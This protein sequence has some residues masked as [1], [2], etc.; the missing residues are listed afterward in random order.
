M[1]SFK[2]LSAEIS[3]E[4]SISGLKNSEISSFPNGTNDKAPTSSYSCQLQLVLRFHPI[5][6]FLTACFSIITSRPAPLTLR[7]AVTDTVASSN[8]NH[9]TEEDRTVQSTALF[10]R[11]VGLLGCIPGMFPATTVDWHMDATGCHRFLP[12]RT[13]PACPSTSPAWGGHPLVPGV[14]VVRFLFPSIEWTGLVLPRHS[15]PN[16]LQGQLLFF[17]VKLS[18]EISEESFISELKTQKFHPS[19]I[20]RVLNLTH[21]LPTVP[22]LYLCLA[23]T[24]LVGLTGAQH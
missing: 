15:R 23:T 5:C 20:G 17:L 8:R 11:Q 9:L 7:M 24:G 14:L 3:A 21:Q 10:G 13:I 19:S 1:F 16:S 2:G 18:S 12:L 6:Y 4:S 22:T